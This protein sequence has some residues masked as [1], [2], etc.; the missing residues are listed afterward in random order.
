MLFEHHL[1]K[2]VR[3]RIGWIFKI[4]LVARGTKKIMK[5]GMDAIDGTDGSPAA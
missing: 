4:F 1:Q 3:R 5:A 2:L